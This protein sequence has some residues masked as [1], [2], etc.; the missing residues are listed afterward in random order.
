MYKT[1]ENI[2][3]KQQQAQVINKQ[4]KALENIDKLPPANQVIRHLSD[5]KKK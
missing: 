5:T 2:N 3:T 1:L 4:R